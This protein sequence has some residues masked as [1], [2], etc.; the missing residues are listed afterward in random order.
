M[1]FGGSLLISR[2]SNSTCGP[3]E[4]TPEGRGREAGN[5]IAANQPEA[6]QEK[7]ELNEHRTS[8]QQAPCNSAQ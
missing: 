6:E 4:D 8:G 1:Y 2:T 5:A 7:S 3:K